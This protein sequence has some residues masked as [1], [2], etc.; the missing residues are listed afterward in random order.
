MNYFNKLPTINYN[1]NVAV[2]L[3]ARAKLSDQIKGDRTAFLPY[4]VSDGDRVDLLSQAYYNNPGYSWLVWFSNEVVDPYYDMPLSELDLQDYII[5]KYGSTELAQRK[6][7]HYRTN[8]KTDDSV[9]TIQQYESLPYGEQKYWEPVL[10][11]LFNVKQY[12]RKND[13]QVVSTNRLASIDISGL[14]GQF[15]IGEEVQYNGTNY[16]FCTYASNTAITVN[17]ITGQFTVSTT[18]TGKESGAT[19]AVTACNNAISTTQAYDQSLYWEA[20]SYY[21]YELEENEKKKEILLLDNRYATQVE[22]D[23][24]RIMEPR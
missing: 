24:K 14:S 22:Q 7:I 5:T 3:L 15:K 11:Y 13:G 16:G 23:L 8:G 1:K 10:D 4:T 19:A 9:L 20:V 21:D 2:N 17:N 18:V 12:K 6:I